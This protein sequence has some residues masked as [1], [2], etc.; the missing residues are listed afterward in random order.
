MAAECSPL[1]KNMPSPWSKIVTATTASPEDRGGATAP[2]DISGACNGNV[3]PPKKPVWNIPSND[4]VGSVSVMGGAASWPSLSDSARIGPKSGPESQGQVIKQPS[5][6]EGDGSLNSSANI[7]NHSNAKQGGP[8]R[9]HRS[10][11]PQGGGNSNN[12]VS[13]RHG[14]FSRGPP[15]QPPLPPP[16]PVYRLPL[17]TSIPP[18]V[19]DS[20]VR[21]TG[22]MGGP[23]VHPNGPSDHPAP[24]NSSGRRNFSSHGRGAGQNRN[25]HGGQ[26]DQD[27][28][29]TH[30]VPPAP[31][32][33]PPPP[34][35]GTPPPYGPIPIMRPFPVPIG[36][37]M[38]PPHAFVPMLPS[39]SFRGAPLIAP[40]PRPPIFYPFMEPNLR[41]MVLHQIDYYFSDNNLAGDNFLRSNMDDE[42]WVHISLI[43]NFNRVAKLTSNVSFI[44]DSMRASNVVEVEG[45]K[46]RRR[47]DWRMWLRTPA[48]PTN[49]S[50]PHIAM[51]SSENTLVDSMQNVSSLDDAAESSIDSVSPLDIE[52]DSTELQS[53]E[54]TTQIPLATVTTIC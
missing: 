32:F 45:D 10:M 38:A 29:D 53:V 35:P 6:R 37:D 8:G 2:P 52:G 54:P 41:L 22:P 12:G 3:A 49:D 14:G 30:R 27:Q 48:S 51:E 18:V 42:G 44:L 20:S 15:P 23:V 11:R 4:V 39:E 26:R 7:R 13:S 17:G 9:Q 33:I 21:G 24:G 43:A 34:S 25:S 5:P 50:A 40:A 28:R 19:V 47:G 16:F 31:P 36:F 46:L 1:S